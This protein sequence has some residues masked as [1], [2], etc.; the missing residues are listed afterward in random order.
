MSK[1]GWAHTLNKAQ[2]ETVKRIRREAN[3]GRSHQTVEGW[4]VF[5]RPTTGPAKYLELRHHLTEGRLARWVIE[6]DGS[7]SAT[8]DCG[9]ASELLA[10]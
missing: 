7:V 2:R 4:S 6:Q 3:P 1:H 9:S 5:M 10:A 8:N